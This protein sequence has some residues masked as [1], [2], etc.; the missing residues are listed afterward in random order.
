MDF[1]QIIQVQKAH[2]LPLVAKHVQGAHVQ[3]AW[4]NKIYNLQGGTL[5]L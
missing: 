3:G 1:K 4:V 2:P 5:C